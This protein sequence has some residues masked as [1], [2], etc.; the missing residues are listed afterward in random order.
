MRSPKASVRPVRPSGKHRLIVARVLA[1]AGVAMLTT[2]SACNTTEGVGRDV[3]AAG[4]GIENAA[5]SA[6]D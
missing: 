6:K 1:L 5:S 3:K 4:R 2:L